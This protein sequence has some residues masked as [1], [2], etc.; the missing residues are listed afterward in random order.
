[1]DTCGGSLSAIVTVASPVPTI[2]GPDGEIVMMTVSSPSDVVSSTGEIV[3]STYDDPA[4]MIA[5]PDGEE[6]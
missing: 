4:D 2:Y 6:K 1:M 5:D 3:T